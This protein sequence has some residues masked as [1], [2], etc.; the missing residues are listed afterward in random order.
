MKPPPENS[1]HPKLSRAQA[2]ALAASSGAG[3]LGLT[4]SP[5]QAA[6]SVIGGIRALWAQNPGRYGQPLHNEEGL[7][8]VSA[9][10]R[11][12]QGIII[13]DQHS[14]AHFY[15]GNP[16]NF[17]RTGPHNLLRDA[18]LNLDPQDALIIGDSQ[19]GE[20]HR[21][22]NFWI[23]Q[24]FIQA[25]YCPHFYSMGGIGIYAFNQYHPSYYDSVINNARALPLGNPG[26]VYIQGSGNDLWTGRD[27]N[28]SIEGMRAIIRR[29][30]ELYPSSLIMVSEVVSRRIPEQTGRHQFSE[31]LAALAHQEGINLLPCRYWITDKGVAHLM[32]D[33]VHLA[34]YAGHNALAPHLAAWLRW[35]TGRGFADVL[36]HQVFY[37]EINWMRTSGISTG[38]A[39][40]TYRPYQTVLR[41]E[42]AAFFYRLAGSPAYIPPATSPFI[43]VPTHHHFYREIAWMR[44]S[45]ITTGWADGT[46]RPDQPVLREQMAAFFY[47]FKGTPAYAPPAASPFIDVPDNQVFYKEISWM[48]AKGIST[49]WADGTYR[50]YQ[51]VLR[52]QMAAFTYR[53]TRI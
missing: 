14:G 34:E 9:Y 10:Q 53:A 38:W 19:V 21:A 7:S 39:D 22:H 32:Q 6:P 36:P 27:W 52:D 47:R 31:R 23:G 11:F 13:W 30:R 25:G 12:S 8:P 35:T 40:G 20:A 17:T 37:Q 4:A 28:T 48:R 42:I 49:G 16:W 29:L 44:A 45:G 51:A 2:L 1:A 46:Y 41:G 43:D 18:N 26:I 3:L 24:G 50:P 5:A 15:P 33:S